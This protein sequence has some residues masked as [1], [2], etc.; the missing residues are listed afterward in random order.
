MN[1][2]ISVIVPCYNQAQYLDECLQSVLDQSYQNWEC[3]IVNDG[4]SDDTEEIANKWSKNDERIK[5]IYKENEG[6]SSA[7]NLGVKISL[8]E[9][10]YFIDSDDSL[11]GNG[12]FDLFI[13]NLTEN[14]DFICADLQE[15]YIDKTVT[16]H[17]FTLGYE[18]NR[19]LE[20]ENILEDFLL[21][22]FPVI[23]CNKLISKNL[24]LKNSIFFREGILHEDELFALDLCINSNKVL[25]LKEITYNYNRKNATS[26]TRESKNN[27]K[28]IDDKI[29]IIN[30]YFKVAVAQNDYFK[31]IFFIKINRLANSIIENKML[32]SNY[33]KWNFYYKKVLNIYIKYNNKKY[34]YKENKNKYVKFIIL[35]IS[36]FF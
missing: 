9:F 20:N 15:I 3:I 5:Y 21:K 22:K 25:V 7:R 2:L 30:E 36:D 12:V 33:K 17:Y 28:A 8:G 6:L 26:I 29:I 35:K 14:I 18:R 19:I 23:A 4:S 16:E 10:I 27:I 1:P 32:L 11:N 13:S 31:K 34:F 24:L